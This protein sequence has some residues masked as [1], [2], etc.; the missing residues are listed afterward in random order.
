LKHEIRFGK[1]Q[2]VFDDFSKCLPDDTKV[3]AFKKKYSLLN[4]DG[5]SVEQCANAV[6]SLCSNECKC[7]HVSKSGNYADNTLQKCLKTNSFDKFYYNNGCNNLCSYDMYHQKRA[8]NSISVKTQCKIAKERKLCTVT[9][10]HRGAT[11]NL[12]R[13]YNESVL[14][15][16]FLSVHNEKFINTSEN[17]E[18]LLR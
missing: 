10:V 8:G 11:A 1:Y 3:L 16:N 4:L 7:V 12:R 14:S 5:L 18:T 13:F 15:K 6:F 17:L 2:Q 9:S